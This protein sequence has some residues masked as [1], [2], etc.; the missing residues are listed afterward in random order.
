MSVAAVFDWWPG[1]WCFDEAERCE[2]HIG[3]GTHSADQ[4]LGA[5]GFLLRDALRVV[6]DLFRVR[7]HRGP[8]RGSGGLRR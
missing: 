1:C 3:V 8:P 5:R 7:V 2:D 6:A 4:C